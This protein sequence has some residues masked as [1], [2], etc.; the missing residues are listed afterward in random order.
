MAW[1]HDRSTNAYQFYV[2]SWADLQR[3]NARIPAF[4]PVLCSQFFVFFYDYHS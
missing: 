2:W 4:A 1:S 3:V